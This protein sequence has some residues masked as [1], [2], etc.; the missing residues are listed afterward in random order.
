[1]AIEASG[2]EKRVVLQVAFDL[3]VN[4]WTAVEVVHLD[5]AITVAKMDSIEVMFKVVKESP[6]E[7]AVVVVATDHLAAKT[8]KSNPFP[9]D[10]IVVVVR[11]ETI[12]TKEVGHKEIVV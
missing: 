12:M 6:V 8:M 9:S 2:V 1:M 5:L 11:M 10:F 3:A 4:S 7:F